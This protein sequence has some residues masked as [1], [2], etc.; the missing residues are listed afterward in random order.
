MKL[1]VLIENKMIKIMIWFFFIVI[2][3]R[4]TNE[5]MQQLTDAPGN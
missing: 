5:Q 2:S 1:F 3:M 4:F